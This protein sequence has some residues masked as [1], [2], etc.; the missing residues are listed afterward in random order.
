MVV[1]IPALTAALALIG[2]G[3]IDGVNARPAALN[4]SPAE[5]A[6]TGN[7]AARGA[8]PMAQRRMEKVVLRSTSSSPPLPKAVEK[9]KRSTP[10]LAR[11][12]ELSAR[13]DH[14]HVSVWRLWISSL[15]LR[16]TDMSSLSHICRSTSMITTM[17]T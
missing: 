13:G 14:V 12:S 15:T 6:A 16:W 10:R 11:R 17:D 8:L 7:V 3:S 1:I 4:L 2:S 5:T 9:A